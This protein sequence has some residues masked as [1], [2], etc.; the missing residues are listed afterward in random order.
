MRVTIKIL[1]G[2]YPDGTI[3]S[4]KVEIEGAQVTNEDLL[5]ELEDSIQYADILLTEEAQSKLESVKNE[6]VIKIEEIRDFLNNP[7]NYIK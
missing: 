1:T 2:K 5:E 4:E 6:M 7:I 3:A